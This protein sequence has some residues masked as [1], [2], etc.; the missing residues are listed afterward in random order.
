[1]KSSE[2]NPLELANF[3]VRRH[4]RELLQK[5]ADRFEK[6]NLSKWLRRA[7]LEY[8]P[9]VKTQRPTPRKKLR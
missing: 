2:Q 5:R 7:G 4:E 1:M 8:I 3:R 6:G 9:D